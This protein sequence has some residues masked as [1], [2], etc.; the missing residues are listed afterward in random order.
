M[1]TGTQY[2]GM[3]LLEVETDMTSVHNVTS[4]AD[5]MRMLSRRKCKNAARFQERDQRWGSGGAMAL[6]FGR[7]ESPAIQ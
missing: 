6:I 1:E 2:C 5:W 4:L 7:N 3:I